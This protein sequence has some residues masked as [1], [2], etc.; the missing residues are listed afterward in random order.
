MSYD[1]DFWK[2]KPGV[3]L[4]HQS[5]YEQLRDGQEVDGLE[6]LPIQD[7]I[8]RVKTA[9][10]AWQQ[11]DDRTFDGG[12]KGTFQIFTTPQFFRIDCYDMGGEHMNV[13]I[14][15]GH[16]FGCPLYDPQV[17]KRYDG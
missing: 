7:M 15:I 13:F 1:L 8:A 12:E 5:V 2:Y 16:E 6:L 17:E 4:D 9:F 14:D 10:A 11:L 3:A